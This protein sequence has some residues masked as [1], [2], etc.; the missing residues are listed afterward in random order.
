MD[1]FVVSLSREFGSGGKYIGEQLSKRLG[2]SCYD[3]ELLEKVSK[4]YKIDY[5][6]LENVDEKQKSSFWYGFA[7]N[8]IFSLKNAPISAEDDLF[9]KQAKV[10]ED[11][12][13]KED[14]ILIGRCSDYI[15]K[16][17]ENVIRIFIYA[18]DMD[19]KIN[20]KREFEG[21]KEEEARKKI[22]SIDK[23]RKDYYEHF[24]SQKWG[25]K[26]NYELCIDTSIVGVEKTIS[27]LENYIRFRMKK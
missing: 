18:S 21:L 6:M 4:D 16:G 11:F 7:T 19:F 5:K 27:I 3:K 22:L 2:I 12:S 14:C 9:L 25:E 10:I 20:R 8:T 23:E 13:K 1:H 17:N 26:S 24:T 15:L